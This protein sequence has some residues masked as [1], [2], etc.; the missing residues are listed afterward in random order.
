MAKKPTF[1]IVEGNSFKQIFEFVLDEQANPIKLGDGT[2]GVVYKI[3]SKEDEYALKLFYE[4]HRKPGFTGFKLAPHVLID[5]RKKFKL[6]T[7]NNIIK[8]LTE[9]QDIPHSLSDLI[10]KMKKIDLNREQ[11]QFLGPCL[12]DGDDEQSNVANRYKYERDA[13]KSIKEILRAIDNAKD[14]Y[15]GVIDIIA[16]TENF[17]ES[18]AYG[19]LHEKINE[20]GTQ[21][22]NYGV[23]MPLYRFTLKE[24]LERPTGNYI[25][26]NAIVQETLN[27]AD[28]PP[29][30]FL[31][32]K[33]KVFKSKEELVKEIN[34]LE[35]LEEHK[36]ALASAIYEQNGYDLLNS[37]GFENRIKTIL[38]F[39]ID[40][41]QGLRALHLANQYHYDLKPAN[42]FVKLEG[43]Q[44]RSVIGDLGFFMVPD[45]QKE[46]S[47][48]TSAQDLLPLGTRHYRS[49]E[50]KDYFDICDAEINRKGELIIRD[51]KFS[52]TIIEEGDYAVFS[53][54][55]SKK[56]FIIE[57]KETLAK[58]TVCLHFDD[59]SKSELK[60]DKRTQVI[61]YKQQKLRT[62]LFG[63]GAIV[64][65]M[66]T[67][68]RSPERFYDKIRS[69]DHI[70]RDVD[71]LMENYEQVSTYQVNDPE[72]LHVFS[73]FKKEDSKAY[74]PKE[75]VELILKSMMY[76]A[77]NNY[78]RKH[79]EGIEKG[80]KE[81]KYY[82]PMDI[83]FDKLQEFNKKYPAS[84]FG[85]NLLDKTHPGIDQ[86]SQSH[87]LN[88]QLNEL[89]NFDLKSLPLRLAKGI[90]YFNKLVALVRETLNDKDN[91]K[92]FCE[93][94]PTNVLVDRNAL[95]L[96]FITYKTEENYLQDLI[97]DLVYAK[98]T[99]DIM[100]PFV[101]NYLSFLRRKIQ[102]TPI[103]GSTEKNRYKFFFLESALLGNDIEAGDWIL[104]ENNL[105]RITTIEGNELELEYH[106]RSAPQGASVVV[107]REE[108][109]GKT[110]QH[111]YYKNIDPCYYYLQMLGI[112]LY[113]IFFVGIGN[114][115]KDKPLLITVAQSAR[116]LSNI[117]EP[118]KIFGLKETGA[119][120]PVSL[121]NIYEH[122][123]FMYLKLIFTDHHKSY[124]REHQDD[125]RRILALTNDAANLQKK[126]ES[127]IGIPFF[128]LDSLITG[129][130]PD[131]RASVL[132]KIPTEPTEAIDF[133]NLMRR[134]INVTIE[135][136]RGKSLIS[137][138][139]G[140]FLEWLNGFGFSSFFQEKVAEEDNIIDEDTQTSL[141]APETPQ[142]ETEVDVQEPEKETPKS[143]VVMLKPEKT[144]SQSEPEETS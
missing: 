79:F 70:E 54:D 6:S 36:K 140:Q 89:L 118:V 24:L 58:D 55:N 132:K 9:F 139:Y 106:K 107:S 134:F 43:K 108:N 40:I 125:N 110:T 57:K 103:P 61:F 127:F 3:K 109:N 20:G 56:K 133:D 67:G 116:F 45:I 47:Q 104:V 39:L 63:F 128:T 4:E 112:Y 25:I 29:G 13:S 91:N 48:R 130:D 26:S 86:M 98:I 53:R 50:Q 78:F 81:K 138:W 41:S 14:N 18:D 129:F 49:P 83:I 10:E 102:L 2:Y 85:N 117:P 19:I 28:I 137:I 136:Y 115:T 34:D 27:S 131:V 32:L 141:P 80:R 114:A 92:Y 30:T 111:I 75:I 60:P 21:I 44:T 97:G 5:F 72:L 66:I 82:T 69:F 37:M 42:I 33:S 52:D 35:G 59:F 121:E 77:K 122:L 95:D 93:L 88:D 142:R 123:A 101:P 64:F 22:S 11:M 105:C 16:G 74:V 84:F 124:F 65:D 68:G 17:K 76:K 90:W 100:N 46:H 144:G 12:V 31:E 7:K 96:L 62:D 99:R 51:P 120:G 1:E 87:I 23:I 113:H 73:D 126:I 71:K 135:K 38:P 94:L 15:A 8:A 143:E 119:E